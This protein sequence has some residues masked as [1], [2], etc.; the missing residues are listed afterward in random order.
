MHCDHRGTTRLARGTGSD[1]S[2]TTSVVGVTA[3]V[4]RVVRVT[5]RVVR[6]VRVTARVV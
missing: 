1:A 4:V 2:G 5:A 3:R 6:V